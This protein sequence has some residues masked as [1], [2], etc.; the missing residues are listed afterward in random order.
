M[1]GL[2]TRYIG[3]KYFLQKYFKN[4]N[5]IQEI[6]PVRHFLLAL[7]PASMAGKL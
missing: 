7:L 1:L 3:F 2:L 6:K 5:Y 4:P